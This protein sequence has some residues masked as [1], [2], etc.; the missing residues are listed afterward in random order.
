MP[1]MEELISNISAE[2]TKNDGDIWMSKINL[3]YG[4]AKLSNEADKHCVFSIIG[5]GFTG[6]YR[7]KK[8]FHGLSDIP[9]IFQKHIHRTGN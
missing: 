2:I 9:T 6:L 3:D 1:N 7:F 8:G 5:G 4:Q